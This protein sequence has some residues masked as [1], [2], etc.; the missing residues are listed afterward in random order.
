DTRGSADSEELTMNASSSRR[1]P[2]AFNQ[3]HAPR[4]GLHAPS[5]TRPGSLSI[6]RLA[7]AIDLQTQ[8]KV[9]HRSVNGSDSSSLHRL[10]DVVESAVAEYVEFLAAGV[11][12]PGG[13][14][15]R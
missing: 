8:L 14:A 11:R 10:F 1:S 13:T 9:A 5:G 3:C 4:C 12:Q 2:T 6:R 7:D 15:D